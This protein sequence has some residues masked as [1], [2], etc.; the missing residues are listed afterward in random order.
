MPEPRSW[1]AAGDL[2]PRAP[3]QAVRGPRTQPTARRTRSPSLPLSSPLSP[4]GPL[5][6]L[7]QAWDGLGPAPPLG[8]LL[9]SLRGPAE[10][11]GN[12]TRLQKRPHFCFWGLSISASATPTGLQPTR[13]PQGSAWNWSKGRFV[14]RVPRMH[15]QTQEAGGFLTALEAREVGISAHEFGGSQLRAL[16]FAVPAA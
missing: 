12:P 1:S 16:A 9:S 8:G 15:N 7:S 11:P 6:P 3:P 14:V 5:F 2:E 4:P 10:L 13:G